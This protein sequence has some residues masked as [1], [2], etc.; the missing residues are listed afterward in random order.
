MQ[1]DAPVLDETSTD[2][3]RFSVI[4]SSYDV[5]GRREIDYQGPELGLILRSGGPTHD[6]LRMEDGRTERF[7]FR[8][9]QVLLIPAG[10]RVRG[11]I[12][13][14]GATIRNALLLAESDWI[15]WASGGEFELPHLG[16][17]WSADLGN[18]LIVEAMVALERET[19]QPGPM[20]RTY[21]E[22][23][24]LVIL[25][26]VAR[27]HAVRPAEVSRSDGIAPRRLRRVIDYIEAHLGED[28]SLLDLAVEA[29]VS[30]VHF[31][32]QF[33]RLAGLS[34]H[35]YVLRRRV[36]RAAALLKDQDACLKAL[37]HE[38]GFSSQSHLTSAFRRVYGTTPGAYRHR[39]T[40][41]E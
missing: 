8:P 21:A 26:E 20:G 27:H 32:R 14:G 37:A 30:R 5:S 4:S 39:R 13:G 25:T 40:L 33:K 12:Q 2:W 17:R 6:V 3:P 9:G 28:I 11:Y 16:L 34:P 35:Q 19:Q 36:E 24:A 18:P 15:A 23:L 1:F 41:P 38:V 31:V 29:G 22:S 7:T 10:E